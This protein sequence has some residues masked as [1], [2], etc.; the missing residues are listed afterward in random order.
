[1][2]TFLKLKIMNNDASKIFVAFIA[3]A[4]VGAILGVLYAPAAGEETRQNLAEGARKISD[5]V[6][7]K[8]EEGMNYVGSLKDKASDKMSDFLRTKEESEPG[9]NA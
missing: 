3:G 8:A 5:K 7:S 9:G 2:L 1:L 6:R 4:A